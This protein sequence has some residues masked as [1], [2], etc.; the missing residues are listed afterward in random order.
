MLRIAKTGLLAMVLATVMAGVAQAEILQ[1]NCGLPVQSKVVTGNDLFE[2]TS[3]TFVRVRGAVLTIAVPAG[4]TRCIKVRFTGGVT[5]KA[6][7][8]NQ[9]CFIRAMAGGIEMNPQGDAK[10]RLSG[11]LQKPTG[12]G[13]QWVRRLGPGPHV[14]QIQVRSVKDSET[15]TVGV[16]NWMMDVE[17]LN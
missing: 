17:E 15:V 4:L 12:L 7:S 6:P 5:C 10:Q 14:I 2:T 11:E 13:Y 16:E 9:T 1:T 3:K 8:G